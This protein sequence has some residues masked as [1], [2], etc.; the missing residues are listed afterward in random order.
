MCTPQNRIT[1]V[2]T[3][4]MAHC[5]ILQQIM[6]KATPKEAQDSMPLC[7]SSR[8]REDE[9]KIRKKYLVRDE[10]CIFRAYCIIAQYTAFNDSVTLQK[11]SDHSKFKI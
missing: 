1:H 8:G 9:D 5:S 4:S 2:N 10:L 11:I 6:S 3:M 7:A